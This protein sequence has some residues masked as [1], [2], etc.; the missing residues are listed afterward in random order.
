V[1]SVLKR[2]KSIQNSLYL[3]PHK[4]ELLYLKGRLHAFVAKKLSYDEREA[5]SKKKGEDAVVSPDL[6]EEVNEDD[7]TDPKDKDEVESTFGETDTFRFGDEEEDVGPPVVSGG[8]SGVETD[9]VIF[10]DGSG[11][12]FDSDARDIELPSV[13]DVEAS[14]IVFTYDLNALNGLLIDQ[15]MELK[16]SSTAEEWIVIDEYIALSES[17]KNEVVN[18]LDGKDFIEG[19][20]VLDKTIKQKGEGGLETTFVKYRVDNEDYLVSRGR[21]VAF[22]HLDGEWKW[23]EDGEWISSSDSVVDYEFDDFYSRLIP[24][25]SKVSEDEGIIVMYSISN[26]K[27]LR[28]LLEDI[29]SR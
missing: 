18:A 4:A 14:R 16:Y 13:D 19:V 7:V 26:T 12:N 17:Q 24:A 3:N 21:T 15:A 29:E 6:D 27:L 22:S 1:D 20:L 8:R 23:F 5:D 9:S 28:L 11:E 10:E 2:I 25:L